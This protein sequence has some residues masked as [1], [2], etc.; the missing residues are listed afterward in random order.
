MQ[1]TIFSFFVIFLIFVF[2]WIF[3]DSFQKSFDSSFHQARYSGDTSASFRNF[4]FSEKV[5]PLVI[6][7]IFSKDLNTS[8]EIFEINQDRKIPVYVYLKNSQ[9]PEI[10]NNV[11]IKASDGKI[12]VTILSYPEIMDL[13][14]NPQVDRISL[15][16]KPLLR[17]HNISE[18]VE[19]TYANLAQQSGLTGLGVDL[20]I[21]DDSFF[22][23]NSEIANNIGFANL[24]DSGNTCGGSISCNMSPGNSH[25]TAVAE[26]VVDMAPEINL[27]LY[28]IGNSVDFNN[29]VDDALQKGADIFS[30][31]LGFPTGGNGTTGFY[32][33]GTSPVALKVDEAND[34][35]SLVVV[36][37]GNEGASHWQGNYVISSVT[38]NDLG[39]ESLRPMNYQSIMEFQP[40]ATGNQPACLPIT[41]FGDIY[42]ASWDDWATSTNDYDILLFNSDLTNL[43]GGGI[44]DQNSG[45]IPP[46]ESIPTGPP[47]GDGCLVLASYSSTEDHF[48]HIDTENNGLD[49]GFQIRQGSIGTPADAR[50]ALAVGAI[51]QQTDILENFS[52]SGPTD[53]GRLKPEI[54]GPD[55]TFNHQSSLNPFFG[56]SSSA[57][58]VAGG[59]ALILQENPNFTPQQVFDR[60]IN[61]SFFKSSYSQD[62]L[63]GS[64]SGKVSFLKT[65]AN[66]P[67]IPS[68]GSWNI[69]DR[70][71]LHEN[72]LVQT[73]IVI[74]N[75]ATLIIPTGI[76]L[77]IDLQMFSLQIANGGGILIENSGSID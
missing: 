34:A 55:G 66:C 10:L 1:L 41:D 29:A 57:P 77:D 23:T 11:E 51:N 46:L 53:D 8:N 54:C 69:V 2:P 67:Q 74:G 61:D 33:D 75:G 44:I 71:R 59:A 40:N 27:L 38:P 26:V 32:R 60:L 4:N 64:N 3:Q 22:I 28:A 63:C 16:I 47:I 30:I 65:A 49:S 7:E 5:S 15:P 19:F 35:G 73:D 72:I 21:I 43:I 24:Y 42:I 18:G 25:G 17:D 31:S 70:C 50:G 68:M 14:K 9:I 13:S 58:H 37:A 76:N 45:Q 36:S 48:F 12:V 62:N 56:T 6:N 52:S 20:A 39:I